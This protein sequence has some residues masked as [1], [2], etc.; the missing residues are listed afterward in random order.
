MGA[1]NPTLITIGH[2]MAGYV[3]HIDEFVGGSVHLE[4]LKSGKL[5]WKLIE[6]RADFEALASGPTR[7]KCW[8]WRKR[9]GRFRHCEPRQAFLSDK[10]FAPP[11][12]EPPIR[13][14]PS[15]A[16]IP[17]RDQLRRRKPTDIY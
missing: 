16:V 1:G 11:F 6:S 14:V 4:A 13:N 10:R 17:V 9:S 2:P 8:E 15:L 3:K 12:C 7:P 5:P